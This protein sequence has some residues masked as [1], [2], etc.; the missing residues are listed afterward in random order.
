MIKKDLND[1][2]YNYILLRFI[3]LIKLYVESKV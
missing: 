1:T 3:K 2:K